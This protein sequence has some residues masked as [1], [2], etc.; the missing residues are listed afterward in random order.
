LNTSTM[1]L[2]FSFNGCCCMLDP[3]NEIQKEKNIRE[4]KEENNNKK[5]PYNI[6]LLND[7]F[8]TVCLINYLQSISD[9]Q[10]ECIEIIENNVSKQITYSITRVL[11]FRYVK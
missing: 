9:V 3:F 7:K 4:Q 11:K 5:L 8:N 1:S 10:K 2:Y 6:K